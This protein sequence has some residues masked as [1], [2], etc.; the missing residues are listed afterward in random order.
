[1]TEEREHKGFFGALWQNLTKGAQNALEIARVGRLA[2]EQHTPFVVERKTRMFRLRHYGRSPGVLAVDAPLLMV[3]PLMV[4]AEIYDIDPASSAVAMLTQN[5][6]DVWVVDFGAPEDEEGGLERTLDDHVRAV[7]EAIDHVRSLTG[8]DVHVAGYS[9]GGMFCYQTAAYRRS[10]GMRSLI[11]FGSPVDIHRNMR[12]QN[13]LATRLID[14]MSGVTRSMLDAIGALPGQFSS[15]GFRVLSAGKEAKQLVDFVSNLHDRDALVR[16]ESS[17]RFLHGE[18]FVAWPGPALRSFYEQFVVEN[19]MS[20]GGFVID[21]RTLTLADITCPILYFVGERDEFARAPAVHGIRAAAPNAAIFHAVLRTGHFGLVVGSLALKHTWPTVVEWL[22]F[23]EGKGER[24]ALSRASLA[25]EQTESAT[26]PRLEQN[27]EDVEYNARLLLDTAKGTA[28]L[29]RKSVGGFTHTVTSMFDNLRYQVPR[30]ARLERIDAET[31][32]SV[33]LELAQQAARNP[34]GTFFLWQGRAHSYADADRR[35]N[36]VVRGLIACHVKPA[37]R[38]GVLMNGRPTY[39]SVVA[40]LSRLGAVAVLISPDAARISAKHACAL[41]AVEILIADPENAERARQSFQGAVLV[42]GGG[43]GPRQLPDGVVDMERIDPEGVVLPDWYRPNPG[44]ARDL[45]LVFFSVGKDDLPRATR[46]SNHRW[47]VAAYGA[48]AASTLTVKDTVYCCMPLDHAAGLLVSVGGALAG[49]AR[50]A[51]AEAF[52]P[53]RFWAEARRYGVTV[54]YY[55]GEMCRDLVAVPHSA[56]DN[57]HPVR[58]FAGSGMRADVWEQ[59]VQ[60]F[61]TSVL[62]F[63]ATTEGNAVLANVSGHKRG[64]LGRP[65]PGGAEIALVAYDFDRDALTTSTDGK[66]LRCFADQPGMLL[67]RVDSNASMLN[68]RLSVPSPEVGGD[69]TGR[70]VHGAFDASDTWF[71]TGDILRCDADGDYWFVDRVADIVRTAQGPVATTRVED[72]LYMWPAIARATAYG[73]RLAGAS[74]ELPMASIVL[75]PGQVLDRHGLG[76]HVASLLEPHARPRFLRVLSAM[77]MTVGFRPMRAQLRHEGVPMA[78]AEGFAYDAET[79][80][81]EPAG[82]EACAHVL[83]QLTQPAEPPRKASLSVPPPPPATAAEPAPE[84]EPAPAPN[85]P[86][87]PRPKNKPKAKPTSKPKAGKAPKKR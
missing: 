32:V 75:H 28:D 64:S 60:R 56:T 46:I 87:A 22:L 78:S 82:P 42:L 69:G 71:I 40:A 67:A 51:L 13:E 18:G 33:G 48:A 25:T 80:C 15:I 73:A 41:G 24:P 76:H 52:E 5:G 19:R 35:V 8:S 44:R 47:A 11:T 85:S 4:T 2:P 31:Q 6:V 23:Q 66:L 3:P 12:V 49:G 84:V 9:Q 81:Y 74:H 45:A 86:K 63:Y 20:Q 30:L 79:Q 70:F 77:P 54:V 50:I 43:S 83:E 59:L 55:A 36:Y 39:L 53:T 7:S 1:M 58:L 27:L 61:E 38:V 16:G 65:L 72:V 17:R 37:M 57:A 34:Q 68:G 62:E 21:G 14:S 10:E 29:V 26:E